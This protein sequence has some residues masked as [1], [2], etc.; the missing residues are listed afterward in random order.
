ME[1]FK[2]ILLVTG[3]GEGQENAFEWAVNLAQKNQGQLTILDLPGEIPARKKKLLGKLFSKALDEV[4]VRDRINYLEGLVAPVRQELTIE[5]KTAKGE[6]SHEIIKAVLQNNYDLVI[7]TAHQHQS[8]KTL[9]FGSTDM[10][11]LRKCACPV[12][13][14]KQGEK[15][16]FQRILAAVD[17]EPTSD[18]QTM[19]AFN[20]ELME[21]ATE[22]ASY[23]SSELYFVHAWLVFGEEM[24]ESS[25]LDKHREEI[26]EWLKVQR[27][28]LH[29]RQ[30]EFKEKLDRLLE[31]KG[32]NAL[33]PEILMVEGIAEEV[34][35]RI[36]LEKDADLIIMGTLGRR[37][38]SGFFMGNTAE[39]ILT[40]IKCSVL[41]IKPAWFV[42]P[43]TNK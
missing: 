37:G 15:Q 17:I 5:I 40:Q 28:E 8:F 31:Q 16:R 12:C 32:L 43:V 25:R 11:L 35:P 19:D 42:S 27:D 23:E 9:L 2:K 36:A 3:S 26:E 13:I 30:E 29:V 24:L 22:L 18:D 1:R 33:K 41:A 4:L 38:L 34:I 10:H 39:N 20:Q 21:I 14:V 6:P 7:K